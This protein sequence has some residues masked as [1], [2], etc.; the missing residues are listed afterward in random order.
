MTVSHRV[1]PLVLVLLLLLAFVVGIVVLA[2]LPNMVARLTYAVESGQAHAARDQLANVT[3][4]SGAFEQVAKA[5][6]PS[7]VSVSWTKRIQPTAN[8]DSFGELFGPPF[9]QRG[10]VEESLGTG[11]IVS[12]DGYILTNSHVVGKSNEVTITLSD[13]RTLKGRL[14]GRDDKTDLAVVK[15]DTSELVPAALGDS[16]D[17]QVGQWVVAIG[18]PFGLQETVTAGIISAKGR[19]NVGIADYEDFIQTDAAI[20]PGNS[21]GPLVNLQGKVIGI[22][23]AIASRTGGY[24]GIGFA[25]PSGMVK[26]VL[27]SILKEGRVERGWLGAAIQNLSSELAKSFGYHST[28]GA[29]VGGVAHNGPAE[30]AGL[31]QGDV[32]VKFNGKP[33]HNANELRNLVAETAPETEVRMIVFREGKETTLT[34]KIGRQ[35]TRLAQNAKGDS[36]LGV[37]VETLTADMAQ[38]QSLDP[39]EKGALVTNVKRGSP[40]AQAGLHPGDIIVTVGE[41]PIASADQFRAVIKKQDVEK[42]IRMQVETDGLQ[43]FVFIKSAE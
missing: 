9:S 22:N 7:V 43:R 10:M 14:I 16:D 25:I 15:I 42:G 27:E 18:S 20:N 32:I 2:E 24:Q 37:S 36:D 29:L 12:D 34:V 3:D 41:Q 39:D 13:E 1:F 38:Q 6:R 28:D 5:M 21:G 17:I 19:A 23:T 8:E 11:V 31:R 4:F 33:I 30:K 35:E 26:A 40:A